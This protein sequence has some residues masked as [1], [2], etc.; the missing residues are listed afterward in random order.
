MEPMKPMKPMS[1]MTGQDPWWPEGLGEPSTAG[2]E[3]E[4]RYAYFA[5][6]HRL[7]V[8]R[9]GAVTIYDTADREITGVSQGQGL[10]AG[11]IRF[12][13]PSGDVSLAHL[14]QVTD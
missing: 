12:T 1:P 14:E 5:G 13:S 6:R 4:I 8:S 11:E 3:D 2:N 10:E 9:G 7:A